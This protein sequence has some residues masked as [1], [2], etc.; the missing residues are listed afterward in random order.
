MSQPVMTTKGGLLTICLAWPKSDGT[1]FPCPDVSLDGG[2]F[3]ATRLPDLPNHEVHLVEIDSAT[4][5]LDAP[6]EAVVSD[7]LRG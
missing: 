4:R 3:C 6:L 7:A 1:V 5:M 2:T